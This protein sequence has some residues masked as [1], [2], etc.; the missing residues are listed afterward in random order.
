[1][2]K[3]KDDL[4]FMIYAFNNEIFSDAGKYNYDS[5]SVFRQYAVSP[6]GH[7]TISIEDQNYSISQNLKKIG[8]LK[9][10]KQTS[11]YIWLSA[12][13]KAYDKTSICRNFIFLKPNTFI[14]IDQTRSS[15]KNLY[16]QHFLLGPHM[17]IV[18]YGKTNFHAV[19]KDKKVGIQL[20]Q[21]VKVEKVN[22]FR[23][24]KNTGKGYIFETFEN[25]TPVDYIEFLKEDNNTKYIT[26]IQLNNS[27]YKNKIEKIKLKKG[28]LK[29]LINNES[30]VFN[31]ENLKL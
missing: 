30:F 10:I 9:L 22:L 11:K 1:V 31:L 29:L 14:I 28:T 24:N 2:H 18:D 15:N 12:I 4:S 20:N 23:A 17:R 8:A 7:N 26:S 3:Q 5:K 27:Y 21:Y 16:S 19:S 6:Q 13:N 25:E